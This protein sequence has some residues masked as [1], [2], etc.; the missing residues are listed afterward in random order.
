MEKDKIR[1]VDLF[2]GC[3]GMSL[4]FQNAGFDI[5]AAFDNWKPAVE[6]YK[7]NFNHPIYDFD[8]STDESKEFINELK[9]NLIIGGPPCQ[10]FSSA[11]KRDDTLGRAD[12]TISYA[13]IISSVKPEY[14]I[15]ENVER[16]KKSRI[17]KEAIDILRDSGYGITMTVL[18][19][20]F[21]GVPQA[22]KRFFMIGRLKE[23]DDFLMPYINEN[24]SA[25]PMSVFDYLGNS[26]GV[27]NYYRHP[28]SYKRRG[29]F[30]IF[31]PS[32]T[33][34]GVNRP[35]PAGY[36]GHSGDP[37]D[38]SENVRSLTT[39]ER[40]YIQTFPKSFKFNGTKTNLEQI[41]GN[42]VPVKLGEYLANCLNE[43]IAD[44][45]LKKYKIYGQ[46][47]MALEPESTV[48]NNVYSS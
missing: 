47:R 17:L 6:V 10:D 4:G 32:P 9:P 5:V 23:K 29:V 13:K 16:I 37:V 25:K 36:P 7:E 11:G 26:L 39:K 30:S 31:E 21:C 42:A 14:F 15:M 28:R 45:K 22:R 19:A 24:L 12:L 48:P 33:V 40:S 34:R 46:I 20:S 2:S 1:T 8:L 43:Y 44:K 35:I 38:V 27:E 3:G 41:I 18:N